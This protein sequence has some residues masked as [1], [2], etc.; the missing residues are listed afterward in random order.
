MGKKIKYSTDTNEVGNMTVV[1][2]EFPAESIELIKEDVTLTEEQQ[3]EAMDKMLDA[4][5]NYLEL[6]PEEQ[7]GLIVTTLILE[8]ILYWLVGSGTAKEGSDMYNSHIGFKEDGSEYASVE[9]FY[10][11]NEKN[12]KIIKEAFK[13]KSNKGNVMPIPRKNTLINNGKGKK[14]DVIPLWGDK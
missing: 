2:Y 12:A 1:S 9:M 13:T 6:S 4:N 5:L 11:K 8:S 3:S 14:A 10:I 7:K